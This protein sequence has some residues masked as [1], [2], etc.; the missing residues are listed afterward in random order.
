MNIDVL[1]DQDK[2][3]F[4]TTVAGHEALME[5]RD[6]GEG[7]L[8]FYHTY[9]PAELRGQKIAFYLVQAALQFAKKN[10]YAVIPS[11]SYVARFFDRHPEYA[12]VK[13]R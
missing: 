8:D 2:G 13:A 3:K 9:V 5:Y 11:C 12:S 4:Y 7:R 1:H 6:I 10:G